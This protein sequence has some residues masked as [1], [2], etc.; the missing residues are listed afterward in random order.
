[1]ITQYNGVLKIRQVDYEELCTVELFAMESLNTVNGL[2]VVEKLREWAS[3]EALEESRDDGDGDADAGEAK[4]FF[5][6]SFSFC[7]F[8]SSYS[9]IE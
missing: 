8:F 3:G 7:L 6:F 1:M 4:F 5:S 2:S 9:K